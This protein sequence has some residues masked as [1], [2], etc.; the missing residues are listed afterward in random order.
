[1]HKRVLLL[2]LFIPAILFTVK[3]LMDHSQQIKKVAGLSTSR[4]LISPLSSITPAEESHLGEFIKEQLSGTTGSY[5]VVV[6]NLETDES[7]FLNEHT[8]FKT[9]SLYKLWVM[10]TAFEQI[11]AGKLRETDILSQDINV[12]HN[13][14]GLAS[15]SAQINTQPSDAPSPSEDPNANKITMSVGEALEKMI[16]VSDNY[17]ALLLTERIRLINLSAFLDKNN[18]SESMVGIKGG[19]PI[20]SSYDMALFLK[21]LYKGELADKEYT[22]KMLSLLKRQRL[23]AKLPKYLP[24]DTVIAHKTGELDE[25][26]HDVGIVYAPSGNYIIVVLTE[27]TSRYQAEERISLVSQAVYKYFK[28]QELE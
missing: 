18:F 14:F 17:A 28:N 21:K 1:M 20:T 10:A 11:K 7:S 3:V 16:T 23:N 25:F 5:G 22:D 2:F 19:D 8:T 6:V 27:S 26:T 12:L 13:K 24:K 9:G 15:P 4:E